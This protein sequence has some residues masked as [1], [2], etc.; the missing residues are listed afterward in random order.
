LSDLDERRADQT[1]PDQPS[2]GSVFSTEGLAPDERHAVYRQTVL[3]ALDACDPD[4]DFNIHIVALR[5]DDLALYLTDSA[6]QTMFRTPEMIAADGLDHYIIRFAMSGS[7]SGEFDGQ[8]VVSGPGEV[9][10]C[11]LARP[12]RLRH[13]QIKVLDLFMPRAH[14][15]LVAP[16]VDLHGAVLD[17]HRA[18]LLIE[19]LSAVVRR[20]PLLSTPALPGIARATVELLGACLAMT[21]GRTGALTPE[22]PALLRARNYIETHLLESD[23]T[24]AAISEAMGLSRSTLYRLFE[25]LGGVTAFI[26]ERRLHLAR[27]ALLD[28]RRSSRISEIA[29]ECGFSSESHFS[30]SFRKAFGMRPSDLRATTPEMI[31]APRPRGFSRWDVPQDEAD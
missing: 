25:P 16:G 3:R 19:H 21:A 29:F 1:A 24:P 20:F 6:G 5:L 2:T 30:R 17:G 4:P 22:P 11:D 8:A 7:V 15:A 31:G 27:A 10:C 9:L 28:P 18:G 12:M 14:V 26:W 23:L 13:G